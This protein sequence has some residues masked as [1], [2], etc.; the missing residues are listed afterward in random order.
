MR[1]MFAAVAT[2]LAMLGNGASAD[3]FTITTDDYVPYTIVSGKNVSGVFADLVS[4]ALKEEGHTVSFVPVPWARAIA[5][6][7]SGEASGTMPW[8]KTAEREAK[9]LYSDAVIDAKNVIFFR[10]GG[11]L[12]KELAWNGYGDLKPFR[13]G[14]TIGYWY[15]DGFKKEGIKL[16]LVKRDE[17]NVKKLEAERID[18][19]ITDELV[20]KSLIK[21]LFPGKEAEFDTVD[22]ADSAAALYLITR[23]GNKDSEK[24]VESLNAGMA[25]LKA[26][27]EFEKI[28]AKYVR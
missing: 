10:K 12:K 24:L 20:G 3:S 18:G 2:A 9:F 23:K 6:A 13:M 15:V 21:K 1:S 7:E 28:V 4:T 26:S 19:F 8:F 5:M 16:Q 27:G 25:K 22:K 14:G 11:K 17:Q